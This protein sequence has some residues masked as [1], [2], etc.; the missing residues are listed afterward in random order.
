M[1]RSLSEVMS[2]LEP[3]LEDWIIATKEIFTM[4][5]YMDEQLL[6]DTG[7]LDRDPRNK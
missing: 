2:D 5:Y 4:A 3:Q 6:V 7:R 1:L